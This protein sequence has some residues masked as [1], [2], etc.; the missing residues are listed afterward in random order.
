MSIDGR[1]FV[2]KINEGPDEEDKPQITG[3]TIVALHIIGDG[4]SFHPRV[5]WHS[6]KQVMPNQIYYGT[7][8]CL[9]KHLI[10]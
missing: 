4:E 8:L 3:K 10:G 1:V 6:H 5:C 2:W 7:I 9:R